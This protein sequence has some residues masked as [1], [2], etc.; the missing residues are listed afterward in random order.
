MGSRSSFRRVA[1]AIAK[2]LGV[3]LAT[4]CIAVYVCG[5]I[6]A[7]IIWGCMPWLCGP[8]IV[9]LMLRYLT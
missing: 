6:W 5:Y 1:M 9:Y 2:A 8:I 7:R 4:V 3:I